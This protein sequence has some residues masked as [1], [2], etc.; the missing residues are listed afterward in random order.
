MS[1]SDTRHPLSEKT[2]ACDTPPG[3]IYFWEC[4]DCRVALGDRLLEGSIDPVPQNVNKLF[5]LIMV[6][7]DSTN[8]AHLQTLDRMSLGGTSMDNMYFELYKLRDQWKQKTK[9]HI[10]Q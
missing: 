5:E 9:I 1:L 3:P 7:K 6:Y 2:Y 4:A 8:V 10:A